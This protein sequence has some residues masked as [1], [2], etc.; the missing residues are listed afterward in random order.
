MPS[1]K[2]APNDLLKQRLL[3]TIKANL[4]LLFERK[5]TIQVLF[6]IYGDH[7]VLPPQE[8][9]DIQLSLFV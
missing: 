9:Q 6:L 8:V 5:Q 7:D 4:D 1:L 2:I 3:V